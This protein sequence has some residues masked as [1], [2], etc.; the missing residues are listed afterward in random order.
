MW[1]KY[2]RH[3]TR[4]SI[5]FLEFKS[6]NQDKYKLLIAAYLAS[7]MRE[8]NYNQ[9]CVKVQ[10]MLEETGLWTAYT[11]NASRVRANVHL[12]LKELE[13]L[14]VVENWKLR[15]DKGSSSKGWHKGSICVRWPKFEEQVPLIK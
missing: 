7:L 12:A 13:E 10:K 5:A 2:N 4:L 15:Y 14:K 1:R 11:K 3:T 6:A 8:D 9:T